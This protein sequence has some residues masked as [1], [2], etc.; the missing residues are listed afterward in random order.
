LETGAELP[1]AQVN[2]KVA[3]L[4]N[5]PDS[6]G[7]TV[8]YHVPLAD[9]ISGE[10]EFWASKGADFNSI[11]KERN[12]PALYS[13]GMALKNMHQKGAPLTALKAW[14]TMGEFVMRGADPRQKNHAGETLAS[15]GQTYSKGWTDRHTRGL[16]QVDESRRTGVLG[17]DAVSLREEMVA[18][19][20]A[21]AAS[22]SSS[23]SRSESSSPSS[24]R[25]ESTPP[26]SSCQYLL[27]HQ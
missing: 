1:A 14:F 13:C 9:F 27:L 11:D 7:K 6:N 2:Q 19:S 18:A 4:T 10:Q 22:K 21:I 5:T 8:L 26:P 16:L 15:L 25:S 24:S 3:A 20:Q 12:T 17:P 23:N